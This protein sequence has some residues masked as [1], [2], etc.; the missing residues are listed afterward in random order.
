MADYI[1]SGDADFDAWAS[2]FDTLVLATPT[3]FGET[4]TTASA[5]DS[6]F[7]NWHDA[8]TNHLAKQDEAKA[9]AQTK[10]T[11]RA[12]LVDLVRPMVRRMQGSPSVDASEKAQLGINVRDATPTAAGAP[13][14]NPVLNVGT[15]DRLRHVINFADEGT[16]TSK[17][18][19]AGVSGCEIWMK[20]GGPPPGDVSDCTFLALDSKTPYTLNFDSTDAGQTVH[21]LGRWM[22]TR[23]E[24]GPW[25][26]TVSATV[27]A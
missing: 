2:N 24:A 1:P 6:A 9:F 25:A 7:G 22:S 12:A 20:V 17:A 23:G 5:L 13:L 19:P 26:E 11:K 3:A 14:S 10:E 4:S 16:P 8:Y 18:K 21:Y 27:G 15:A